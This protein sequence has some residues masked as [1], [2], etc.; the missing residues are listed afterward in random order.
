MLK[1]CS[2]S[3][4]GVIILSIMFYNWKLLIGKSENEENEENDENVGEKA[5]PQLEV[6]MI[7]KILNAKV[8]V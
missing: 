2:I 4:M 3:V 5:R 8:L 7:H 1:A 6:T